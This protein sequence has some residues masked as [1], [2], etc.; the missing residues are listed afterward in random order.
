M[1]EDWWRHGARAA[2]RVPLLKQKNT[3]YFIVVVRFYAEIDLQTL[4]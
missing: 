2:S 3:R 4:K 1:E